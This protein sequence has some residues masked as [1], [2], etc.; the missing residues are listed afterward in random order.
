[1]NWLIREKYLPIFIINLGLWI[2]RI[3]WNSGCCRRSVAPSIT[4]HRIQKE[5]DLQI[6]IFVIFLEMRHHLQTHITSGT[7]IQCALSLAMRRT[8]T[9]AE[10]GW[11]FLSPLFVMASL[12][13]RNI[14]A[15]VFVLPTNVAVGRSWLCPASSIKFHNISLKSR[16]VIFSPTCR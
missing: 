2:A 16:W 6:Y 1:M 7:F 10:F 9:A 12:D 13:L 8:Q 14:F 11:R 3:T 15:H 5:G 4:T